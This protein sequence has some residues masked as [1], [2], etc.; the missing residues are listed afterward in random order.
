MGEF[1]PFIGSSSLHNSVARGLYADAEAHALLR[2]LP[3]LGNAVPTLTA[4]PSDFSAIIQGT[5]PA[6]IPGVTEAWRGTDKW[7][8]E[9]RL[10]E[11]FG[12]VQFDLSAD[13]TMTTAEYL[14]YARQTQADFPY[15]IYEREYVGDS[16]RIVSGFVPPPWIEEDLLEIAP[17]LTPRKCQQL[18]LLGGPRTG[19][20][21][22]Q[23]G[24]TTVGWNVCCFGLKRWVFLAP[25]TDVAGLGLGQCLEGPALWFV[26]NLTKMHDLAARGQIRM[27][28]CIQQP[29]DLIVIPQG[30]HHAICNLETS[31]ALAHT[32]VLPSLLPRCW[33]RLCREHPAFAL[34]LQDVLANVRPDLALPLPP[35]THL[36]KRKN[37]GIVA[38]DGGKGLRLPLEWVRV[39]DA[40]GAG[41]EIAAN[42]G[43]W[44]RAEGAANGA[45]FL[46]RT[47]LRSLLSRR[48]CTASV[49]SGGR[50][51]MQQLLG[52]HE[53]ILALACSVSACG[54]NDETG[55]HVL[56]LVNPA[57]GSLADEPAEEEL[58]VLQQHGLTVSGLVEQG[59]EREWSISHDLSC[60]AVVDAGQECL[61]AAVAAVSAPG[62]R[63]VTQV[64]AAPS[65]GGA[66]L[67]VADGAVC[68]LD[69][70][71]LS[72]ALTS[73]LTVGDADASLVASM[74]RQSKEGKEQDADDAADVA[75][76][77]VALVRALASADARASYWRAYHPKHFAR[78][79]MAC[80]DEDS[81]AAHH[82]RHSVAWRR[83]RDW[84]KEVEQQH[85][86][87]VAAGFE[88]SFTE[89]LWAA[90]VVQS[91]AVLTEEEG[92]LLCPGISCAHHRSVR[93]SARVSVEDGF[94][95]LR[96]NGF[97]E[98]G[99]VI[100]ICYDDDTDYLDVFERW[101]FFDSSSNVHTAEIVVP[102]ASLVGQPGEEWRNELVRAWA[103]VGCNDKFKSWWVPDVALEVCPL[104]CAVRSMFVSED[105]VQNSGVSIEDVLT[106]EIARE[107]EARRALA[108]LIDAHLEG[109]PTEEVMGAG[110][111][112]EAAR[113]LV[114]FETR[115]LRS[116]LEMLV[117]VR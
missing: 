54:V 90:L 97:L 105:E 7:N 45:V 112:V 86:A 41:A 36:L 50:G 75:F 83:A 57:D 101:G 110:E 6:L 99:D 53:H 111:E 80:W 11:N 8:S 1:R 61:A 78:S 60:M 109:Y 81:A 107:D 115:L 9:A 17:E 19:S 66:V 70:E 58:R 72:V 18:F 114:A 103:A 108:G 35:D 117:R 84:K 95:R 31:C 32:A 59:R 116:Q 85:R 21:L 73:C 4:H 34:T 22:H 16:A 68:G 93:P 65:C 94:I 33:P 63:N 92:L 48:P 87:L 2:A 3:C 5:T 100:T 30:W 10:L 20:Q 91:H 14:A 76:L 55:A 27:L 28:E 71:L 24:H 42:D 51:R 52:F 67:Y 29:G 79:H 46:H 15:Y 38:E 26:Q 113:Q 62:S 102:P 77:R 39:A 89:F 12:D 49:L 88:V 69:D 98:M 96:A 74:L 43:A 56:C 106:S 82:V 23:D 13:L 104:L 47:W 40:G 64:H 44:R 25:E 37:G